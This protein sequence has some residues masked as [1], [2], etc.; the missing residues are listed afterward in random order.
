[1]KRRECSFFDSWIQNF[2]DKNPKLFN[3]KNDV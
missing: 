1:M 3:V 2:I